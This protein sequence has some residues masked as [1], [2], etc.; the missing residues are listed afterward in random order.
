M[1]YFKGKKLTNARIFLQT[2]STSTYSFISSKTK[3]LEKQMQRSAIHKEI[4][5][6]SLS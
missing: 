2:Q 4:S 1:K 5:F 3:T 6:N